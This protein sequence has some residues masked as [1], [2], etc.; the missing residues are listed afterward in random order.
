MFQ[1]NVDTALHEITHV[2]AFS[3]NLYSTFRDENGNVRREV[4]K[5]AVVRG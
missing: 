3:G 4:T 1:E 2:L 5:S